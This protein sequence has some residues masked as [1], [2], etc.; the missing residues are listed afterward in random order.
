ML[1]FTNSDDMLVNKETTILN[2]IL[3]WLHQTCFSRPQEEMYFL[4]RAIA[5][6]LEGEPELSIRL[7]HLAAIF[8]AYTDKCV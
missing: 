5:R 7:H 1:S 3:N 4:H 8:L 6:P 2:L